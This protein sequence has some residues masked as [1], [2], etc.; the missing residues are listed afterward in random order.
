MPHCPQ[1]ALSKT[2]TC[3]GRHILLEGNYFALPFPLKRSF[4]TTGLRTRTTTRNTYSHVYVVHL[5]RGIPMMLAAYSEAHFR[6]GMVTSVV[7]KS[8]SKSQSVHKTSFLRPLNSSM[9][10]VGFS[11]TSQVPQ[12]LESQ[13]RQG[14]FYLVLRAHKNYGVKPKA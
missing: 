10:N 12:I 2:G 6:T 14:T 4:V 8:I 9:Q 11:T 1:Q 5:Q 7:Y 13:S 3:M